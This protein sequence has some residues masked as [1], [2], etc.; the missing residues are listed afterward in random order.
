LLAELD[1]GPGPA[2]LARLVDDETGRL[3]SL[4]EQSG[5]RA[6]AHALATL[7]DDEPS[8]HVGSTSWDR[9]IRRRAARPDS[10]VTPPPSHSA[11][12]TPGSEKWKFPM[13]AR[14]SR[15]CWEIAL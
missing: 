8:R 14:P 11:S 12:R 2:R 10:T 1:P 5:L 6:L 3:Q 4:G 9:R 13:R 15:A 7:Q